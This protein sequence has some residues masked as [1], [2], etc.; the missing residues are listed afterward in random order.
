MSYSKLYYFSFI[1]IV[2]LSLSSG[3][4]KYSQHPIPDVYVNFSINIL[5]DPEFI[6]L[7]AQNNAMVITNNTIGAVALGYDNNGVIIY[8]GGDEFFAFDLTCPYD[9][10]KSIKVEVGLNSGLATCPVCGSIYVFPSRG[11]PTTDE[12]ATF[13]LK[14]YKA[15]YNPNTGDVSVYN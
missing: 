15:Y 4:E 6:R 13:P 2:F 12:P 3:C 10:P 7:Q 8:N 11:T 9:Y 5:Y 1:S 14:E